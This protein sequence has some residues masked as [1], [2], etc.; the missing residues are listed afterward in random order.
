MTELQ[1][2]RLIG[3]VAYAYERVPFYRE[4]LDGAGRLAAPTSA[5]WTTCTSCRSR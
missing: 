4:L 3:Q 1:T 5:V 2:E